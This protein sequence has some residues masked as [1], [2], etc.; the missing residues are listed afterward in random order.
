MKRTALS[1][2]VA[3]VG[4]SLFLPSAA[5][6]PT[7]PSG[8]GGAGATAL[9]SG[10]LVLIADAHR[11]EEPGSP[12]QP[13]HDED[14]AQAY[15][16]VDG[17][18]VLVLPS[19]VEGLD[20]GSSVTVEVPV[21]AVV[22]AAV[23]RGE[24][25]A[26]A[27]ETGADEA[28]VPPR[29]LDAARSEPAPA[30]SDLAAATAVAAAEAQVPVS[31]AV[32]A[33][34]PAAP[35]PA[36]RAP[37][38]MTV[39]VVGVV[40]A[41]DARYTDAEVARLVGAASDYW[42]DQT[43][44]DVTYRLAGTATRYTSAVGCTDP[45]NLWQEAR[46]ETGF[47]D[48]P[49]RHLVLM[50]PRAASR[51]G[52]CSYGL[53]TIG[54]GAA[55]GGLTY[56]A[57][58]SWPV[59]AHE[60][61]HNASLQHANRLACTTASADAAQSPAGAFA[62]GCSEAA[63]GDLA[64]VM[65]S[66]SLDAAGG[67]GAVGL[68]RLGVLGAG[69]QQAVTTSG[70]TDVA[71]AP[72]GSGAGLRAASV[73]DPRNGNTYHLE[74]RQAV[75]RDAYGFGGR[76]VRD[77]RNPSGTPA[78]LRVLKQGQRGTSVL[79]DPTPIACAPS[80]PWDDDVVIAPSTTFRSAA[81]GVEVRSRQDADGSV[82]ASISVAGAGERHWA[83]VQAPAPIVKVASQVAAALVAP[84]V[85]AADTSAVTVRVT[86]SG[87]VPTGTVSVSEDGAPLGRADLVGGRAT[88]VLPAQVPGRHAL[89]ATYDGD[90]AVEGARSAP[91]VLTVAPLPVSVVAATAARV[92]TARRATVVATVRASGRPATGEVRAV[93]D[94]A[95]VATAQL[96]D[97]RAALVLPALPAGR[98]QLSVVHAGS[99]RVA[100]G[101]RAVTVFVTRAE[102]SITAAAARSTI[103]RGSTATIAVTVGAPGVRATGDV[104]LLRSRLV[105]GR[106]ALVD[107]R[108][109]LTVPADLPVGRHTLTVA[110]PG[111][112]E[113]TASSVRVPVRVVR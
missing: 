47:Q 49:A 25:V 36:S 88:V 28:T 98:R 80:C 91:V 102:P 72:L 9:L 42:S 69:S 22:A 7:A 34:A 70:V 75:G 59:L 79:L 1:A 18:G 37:H 61:G 95:T 97:G 92:T 21:P 39:A 6:A 17:A 94:G 27:P 74:N 66:S 30:G 109:V 20:S 26:I 77:A 35:T 89:V 65:S 110:H 107:G 108:A 53:G 10:T 48:G 105:I 100:G 104:R 58:A 5:A 44:G 50:L 57:D 84:G 14:A 82:L 29:E 62:D 45:W 32:V 87:V 4:M 96:V 78:G 111:S 101:T 2:V 19:A 12:S 16:D 55:S 46:A 31:A 23:V 8:S 3:V 83:E 93:L 99:E 67:L 56:V 73:T 38:E 24:P 90:A 81:D 113:L 85:T 33:S 63:Y 52:S 43:S 71:L 15:L 86:A 60:L 76:G 112:S 51:D 106:A 68:R 54:N 64:D 40:G 41:S 103:A 11:G 13:H